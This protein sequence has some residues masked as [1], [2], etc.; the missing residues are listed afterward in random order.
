MKSITIA[1]FTTQDTVNTN[2]HNLQK[3]RNTPNFPR[4]S[5]SHLLVREVFS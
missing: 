3:N 1:Q 5:P 4:Y 2:S